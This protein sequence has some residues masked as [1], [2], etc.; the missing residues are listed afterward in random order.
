MSNGTEKIFFEKVQLFMKSKNL[1]MSALAGVS[2]IPER[3]LWNWF[4]G[5]TNPNKT[6]FDIFKSNVLRKWQIK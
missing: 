4:A 3:T 2:G 1:N 5:D 6:L